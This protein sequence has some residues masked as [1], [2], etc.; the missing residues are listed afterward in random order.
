METLR[1]AK[2]AAE[3]FREIDPNTTI[4][5]SMIR[6]LMDSGQLPCITVGRKRVTSIEAIER[7]FSEKLGA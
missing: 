2:A 7:Y 5:E 1:T 6:A 4:T 3:Y